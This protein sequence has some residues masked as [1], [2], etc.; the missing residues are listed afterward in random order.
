MSDNLFEGCFSPALFQFLEELEGNN[1]RN[2]FKANKSRYENDV[3]E[4]S[5]AFVRA[6]A[7]PLNELSPHFVADDAKMG[8]SLM[9]IYR[10]TRFAKDKTP[11]KT[12]VGIQFRH[13]AGK[14]VHAPGFYVHLEVD[15]VFLGI[16]MWRPDSQ[17][18]TL[19]RT[20]IAEEPD[21]WQKIISDSG[22]SDVFEQGGESLKRAP[23]GFPNDHPLLEELKR[24]SFIASSNISPEQ[25]TTEDFVGVVASYFW[26]G[27]DY[28]RFQ[29]EAI[30]Q[31]F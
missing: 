4:P 12:N 5:L 14:N 2:W 30:G 7:E 29:C 8:G 23:R 31:P 11:Y 15:N 27:R 10:D 6:M 25:A 17:A 1:N 13:N 22:F 21:T 19:V 16:G 9:R 20:R 28:I 3:R 18:L 24:K 26:K